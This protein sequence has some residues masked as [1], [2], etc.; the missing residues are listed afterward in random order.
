MKKNIALLLVLFSVLLATL[1]ANAQ[2]VPAEG[3][4][5]PL[6]GLNIRSGPG[7]THKVLYTAPK[8]SVFEILE[9]SGQWYKV[10]YNGITGYSHRHFLKI[11]KYKDKET[12]PS[13]PNSKNKVERD[14]YNSSYNYQ[15]PSAETK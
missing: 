11:T 1:V 10:R 15:F 13:D 9:A 12:S 6:V 8:D 5:T 2:Q 7:V 4:V 14:V 3:V